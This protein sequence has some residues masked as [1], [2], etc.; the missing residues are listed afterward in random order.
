MA[1]ARAW[2]SRDESSLRAVAKGAETLATTAMSTAGP[3]IGEALASAVTGET[4][5]GPAQ[6]TETMST[7]EQVRQAT[8]LRSNSIAQRY[9]QHDF[10][11]Q[12]WTRR[13]GRSCTRAARRSRPKC[14]VGGGSESCQRRRLDRLQ[15][16]YVAFC[17]CDILVTSKGIVTARRSLQHVKKSLGD[18]LPHLQQIQQVFSPRTGDKHTIETSGAS[19]RA[20]SLIPTAAVLNSE[21]DRLDKKLADFERL[22]TKLQSI[23][24]DIDQL[25]E[26]TTSPGAP[27]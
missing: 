6:T 19:R 15:C 25:G 16:Q 3:P 8:S 4:Q 13:T 17:V 10:Q 20:M 22:K 26:E 9:C 11:R 12:R 1:A 5:D 27:A 18:M 2:A 23:A 21:I 7:M 14:H 24:E